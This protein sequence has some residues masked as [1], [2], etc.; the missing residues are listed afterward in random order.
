MPEKVL[1]KWGYQGVGQ[2]KTFTVNC[3]WIMTGQYSII[4]ETEAEEAQKAEELS[5]LPSGEYLEFSFE[6]DLVEEEVS[7]PGKGSNDPDC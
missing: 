2:M 6:V 3:S 4:A 7:Q 5:H 1:R